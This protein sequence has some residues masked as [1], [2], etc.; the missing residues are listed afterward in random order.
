MLRSLYAGISGLSSNSVELDVIGNN[1]ANANTVGYKS[2]RVT[3]REMLSQTLTSAQRPVSGGR[4]GINAQQVGLGSTVASIDSIFT[5]GSTLNTGLTNDLAIQGDGFFVLSDGYSNS[6]TRAGAFGL[7]ANSYLVDPSTGLHLQGLMADANGEIVG[8]QFQ[9]LFIDASMTVPASASTS[10]QIYGNL[11]AGSEAQSSVLESSHFM[12]AAD[13]T[14]SLTAL[15]AQNGD[16]IGLSMG[17]EITLT[18]MILD[19]GTTQ[20]SATSFVVGDDGA[21]LDDLAAWITGEL[22]SQTGM[23]AGDVTVTVAADGSI[24]LSNNSGTATLSNLQLTAPSLS[25]FNQSFRFTSTIGPAETGSTYD[26]DR[27]AGRLRAA[28]EDSDLLTEVF[29]SDGETLGLNVSATNPSTSISISGSVGENNAPSNTLSVDE[30]TTMADLLTSLQIAFGISSEPVSLNADGEIVMEGETGTDNALGQVDIREVGEVNP[31]IETSFNFSE[32]QEADDGDV[33]TVSSAIYDSLGEVHNIQI[34]FT[35]IVG[36]N[37][38]SWVAEGEDGEE[39]LEGGSGTVSFTDTG[40]ILAFRYDDDAGGL[41]IRPQATGDVGAQDISLQID[42]G[43]FGDFSGMTQYGNDGSLSSI[44]DGY[45]VGTLLDY[46]INTDGLIIGSFSNDT[47]QTLAKIG[48]ARF[49]NNQ[50]LVSSEGNTYTTSGNSGEAIMGFVG[51]ETGSYMLSGVLEGSNVDLT[52]ELTNMVVAQ[53][54]FQA[55]AKVIST[56]DQILQEIV[57]MIR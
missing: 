34:N 14:D 53:R 36:R 30:T 24:E 35:K 23:S 11:N 42:V 33:F 25:D 43:Q 39:I 45:T 22:E 46:E 21:T 57:S 4:G 15:Y 9:D 28:A 13:G 12:A 18:G 32:I 38:W 55:N 17:D 31:I 47:V 16:N 27:E 50:G 54:A 6:Y 1:I 48:V 20:I 37:E 3:F 29:N 2:S 51:G 40:E 5:Q 7:D 26:A 41:S 19:G 49:A 44:T 56:G 10:L 52:E 8:G